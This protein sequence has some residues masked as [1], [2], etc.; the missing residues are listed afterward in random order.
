VVENG[1]GSFDA[2]GRLA[3]VHGYAYDDTERKRAESA[4]RAAEQRYR[5]LVE[6]IPD[7][8][9]VSDSEVIWFA[10]PAAARLL[11]AETPG[12]LVGHSLLSLFPAAER[13]RVVER[14][15]EAMGEGTVQPPERREMVRLDGKAV[16]VE[17]TAAP[18]DFEGKRAVLRVSRDIT[19]RV[20]REQ[21][22]LRK[23]RELALHAQKV[24]S[25]NAALRVLIEHREQ[26]LRQREEAMR[27]TLSQLVLP[28]LS[29]LG[30]S[31]MRDE[32]RALL[33]IVESNLREISSSFARSLST[34]REKLTPTEIRVADLLRAGKRSKDIAAS[35]HVSESAVAFHRSNIRAKLGLKGK[36]TNLVSF[37]RQMDSH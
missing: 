22:I 30:D 31:P 33:E 34:W 35:L 5:S 21:E 6:L 12:E 10:N 9:W 37:L 25:L 26:E 2:Q 24:E 13:D 20:R 29:A 28:H 32:Q 14:T 1:V 3:Q 23:D 4:L 19:A 11:G 8:V 16:Q 18:C 17:T 36:P 7:A 15:R 27:A